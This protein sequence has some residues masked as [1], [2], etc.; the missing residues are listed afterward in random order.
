MCLKHNK[1]IIE[2]IALIS[3]LKNCKRVATF[4][5][6]VEWFLKFMPH[7]LEMCEL[8]Y[9]SKRKCLCLYDLRRLRGLLSN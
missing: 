2:T 5:G 4:L 9:A 7:F 3:L 6:I 8:L 1:Q